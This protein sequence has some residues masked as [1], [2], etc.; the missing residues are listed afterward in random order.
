LNDK[1]YYSCPQCKDKGW[2]WDTTDKFYKRET[3]IDKDGK[4]YIHEEG[5]AVVLCTCEKGRP[6]NKRE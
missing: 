6:R 1:N 3:R 5:N 2:I 4:K